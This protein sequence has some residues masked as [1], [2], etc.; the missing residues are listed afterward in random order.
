LDGSAQLRPAFYFFTP[1]PFDTSAFHFYLCSE[2]GRGRGAY[3]TPICSRT[4]FK[5]LP[6]RIFTMQRVSYSFGP[7]LP[8]TFLASIST[9]AMTRAVYSAATL[10]TAKGGKGV[11][12]F[13]M[14]VVPRDTPEVKVG[15]QWIHLTCH[16]LLDSIATPDSSSCLNEGNNVGI[17]VQTLYFGS[18]A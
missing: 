2:P 16:I 10:L 7:K 3:D 1:G 9:S 15:S 5:W 12:T 13:E 14:G 4:L 17:I 8:N 6:L 11:S 18:M